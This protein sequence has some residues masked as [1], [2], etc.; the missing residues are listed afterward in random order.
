ML[1]VQNYLLNHT[2]EDLENELGIVV[3]KYDDRITLNYSQINS[4]KL[5]PICDECRGLILS[6]PNYEIISRPFDRFYNLNECDTGKDCDIREMTTLSKEDGS[7]IH[8]NY[9]GENWNIST[10]KM[11]FAEGTTITGITFKDLFLK[12][13]EIPCDYFFD[14][15]S[16]DLT[17][18]FELCTPENRV[19]KRYPNPV[20]Y[21]IG[22]RNKF[23]GE[24]H[25]FE[26]MKKVQSNWLQ[27]NINLPNKY[28]FSSFNEIKKS[29]DDL[30]QLDEGYVLWNEHTGYRIKLKSPSYVAIHH[31]RNDGCLSPKNITYLV[32]NNEY[33]EYLSIFPEDTEFFM[34]YIKSHTQ[35][36]QHINDLWRETHNIEDQKEFALKV[37]DTSIASIMFQLRKG[38]T[39]DEIFY[40]MNDKKKVE[41]LENYKTKE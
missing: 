31:L 6:Y 15:L 5:N 28:M 33:Q 41:L 38:L 32:M 40:N 20:I 2:L 34:P 17:Y 13:L 3:S 39:L 12:T 1:N 8:V 26:Q 21:L 23:T 9:D 11:A 4:P 29:L 16:K 19:V 30:P 10:R 25:T 35:L 36:L 27:S 22:I 37:K 18:I 14:T 24:Y 7:L